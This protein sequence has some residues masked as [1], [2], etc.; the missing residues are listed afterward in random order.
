MYEE[1]IRLFRDTPRLY[2]TEGFAFWDDPHIS[3]SMLDAHLSPEGDGASRKH[4][5]I[6]R[7]A[8]WIASLGA[9]GREPLDLLDLGCGPGLYAE[10]FGGRGFRVTGI[11]LSRRSIEYA[12]QSAARG[13]AEIR[14]LCGDYLS[15]DF[16]E[17]F[18][19]ATLIYCD[20]GVLP[21]ES[22]DVLLGRVLAAL[23]PGGRLILDVFTPAH[24]ADFQDS[25]SIAY[26]SSGFWSP[27]PHLCLQRKKR[28]EGDHFLEQYAILTAGCC[29][30]YN[31]WNHAFGREE[32]TRDL[33]RAGFRQVELY[34]DAAGSSL[35]DASPTICAVCAKG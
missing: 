21:P 10:L 24:Y 19:V 6:E 17:R 22:R 15:I 11:D 23:R 2:E 20:F 28:F 31:I 14:Y 35:A 25:T 33:E 27:E 26:E 3:Q 12:E 9:A 34:G 29:R 13:G 7:S 32:L 16:Q 30:A 8:G 5:F 1:L 4:D 18:D